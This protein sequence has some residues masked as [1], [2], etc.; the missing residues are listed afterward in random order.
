MGEC[1]EGCLCIAKFYVRFAEKVK[2]LWGI[3]ICLEVLFQERECGIR[4]GAL[5]E[6]GGGFDEEVF[7]RFRYWRVGIGG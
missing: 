7:V 6:E 2:G 4:G 3:R 5:M 1:G